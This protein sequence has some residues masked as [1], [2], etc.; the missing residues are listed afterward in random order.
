MAQIQV[1]LGE[2]TQPVPKTTVIFRKRIR[3]KMCDGQH[4]IGRCKY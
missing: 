2:K 3:C 4:C 1:K